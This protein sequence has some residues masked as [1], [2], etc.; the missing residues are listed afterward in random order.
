[1]RVAAFDGIFESAPLTTSQVAI[2]NS[3]PTFAQ[4]LGNRSDAEG[5]VV[6]LAATATDP[7]NDPL[8]YEATNLPPGL[9]INA[10]TGLISGT[11]A[12]GAEGSY[13]VAVSVREGALPDATDFFTW[14]VTAGNTRTG[15][16]LGADRSGGSDDERRCCRSRWW[17]T[18]TTIR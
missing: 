13:N 15:R 14:T 8:T 12:L 6:S 16:R 1:M 5:A 17:L 11:I 18:T 7:D 2:V 10:T 4:D 9:S 3:P